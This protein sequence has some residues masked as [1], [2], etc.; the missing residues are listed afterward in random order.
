MLR[1]WEAANK[2][3]IGLF[4][5][6]LLLFSGI[7]MAAAAVAW[8][9]R[10]L[11]YD[12]VRDR[13]EFVGLNSGVTTA[14]L[15]FY[16]LLVCWVGRWI[17]S[18]TSRRGEAPESSTQRLLY[19]VAGSFAIGVALLLVNTETKLGFSSAIVGESK[20]IGT[21]TTAKW[22]F[23]LLVTCLTP[24]LAPAKL[25]QFGMRPKNLLQRAI[26]HVSMF[27]LLIGVPLA[28]VAIL[29]MP[30]ISSTAVDP[31]TLRKGDI[32]N[33]PAFLSLMNSGSGFAVNSAKSD[34]HNPEELVAERKE[35]FE[36]SKTLGGKIAA[37]K[38]LRR[39]DGDDKGRTGPVDEK[40]SLIQFKKPWYSGW[41]RVRAGDVKTYLANQE[42]INEDKVKICDL[43]NKH[44][45]NSRS[46]PLAMLDGNLLHKE[47]APEAYRHG[48]CN[49]EEESEACRVE[50]RPRTC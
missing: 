22:L 18:W 27:A 6:N 4:F 1:P 30:N 11:D 14:F 24:L 28:A 40:L 10:L 48:S 19:L 32:Y 50:R 42:E 23:G 8:L 34:A 37:L 7:V 2:Y 26:F 15:L 17:F 3:L 47:V 39:G 38:V 13:F 33:W 41:P 43:L 20:I 49:G 46:L 9:W 36:L 35:L 25:L 12:W 44:V 16:I 21:G 45:L 29:A 31:K 5:N